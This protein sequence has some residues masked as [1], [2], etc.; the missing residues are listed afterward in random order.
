VRF[1]NAS[2]IAN[3][4][5]AYIMYNIILQG[6]VAKTEKNQSSPDDIVLHT[7]QTFSEPLM[8]DSVVGQ[9]EAK[10]A[11]KESVLFPFKYPWYFK[12][13]VK[14]PQ[15][16]ILYGP[17]GVAKSK[18]AEIA[19]SNVDATFFH[20]KGS[21]VKSMWLGESE[22]IVEAL[23]RIVNKADKALIFM[24][25]IEGIMGS[26]SEDKQSSTQGIVRQFLINLIG[27]VHY[28]K[29]WFV[30]VDATNFP[31]QIDPAIRRRFQKWIFLT[32]PNLENRVL[33]F[34]QFLGTLYDG[35]DDD[36]KEFASASD[37]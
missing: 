3:I 17:P 25:E 1:K 5:K 26:R 9:H 33:L 36:Y 4:T 8:W 7:I 28:T 11:L 37:G 19:A 6:L 21:D 34:K 22:K 23:F 15:G 10:S 29:N 2:I 20:V 12:A 16:V 14:P 30:L 32:L 31:E 35:S 18:L 13:T 24:D 27:N